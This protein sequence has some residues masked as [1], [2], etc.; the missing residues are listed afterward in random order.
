MTLAETSVA[1]IKDSFSLLTNYDD[2]LEKKVRKDEDAVD[3]YEDELGSYL[4]ELSAHDMSAK[5]SIEVTKMLHLISDL[6]RLSD[7]AVNIAESAQEMYTKKLSFSKAAYGELE[8]L[9]LAIN[10]ILDTALYSIKY[11]D[12][13]M[14]MKVEPLEEVIDRVQSQIKINHI[15]RLK[16][17]ECTI[18][19]GFILTDILT[20]LERIADHC[21]NVA[22]CVIEISRNSLGMHSYT[23]SLKSGNED[24]AKAVKDY[25][26]K[27]FIAV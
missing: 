20:D 27:Y 10:E 7:H 25:S 11:N 13:G 24:Y 8:V 16:N 6:E 22:G 19:L 18:E 3:I 14:A 17:N 26:E 21:S 5:D 23:Q 9:L 1:S 15:N 4:L 12:I 2:K